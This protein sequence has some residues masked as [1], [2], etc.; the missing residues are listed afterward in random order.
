M[1]IFS[2]TVIWSLMATVITFGSLLAPSVQAEE[3]KPGK[4]DAPWR[5]LLRAGVIEGWTQGTSADRR[6]LIMPEYNEVHRKW[7]E[8]GVKMIG[9]IDDHLTQ[10]GTPGSRHYGWYELYEIDDLATVGKMLDLIR[11]SQLGKVRLDKY[12]RYDALI[13]TP[14]IEAEKVFDLKID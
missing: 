13:G 3:A 6:D 10:A 4:W 1:N 9:T 5:V 8:M 7:K 11:R 2:R 14:Q 12:M